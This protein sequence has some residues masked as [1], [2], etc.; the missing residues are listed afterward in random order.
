M[1]A[2]PLRT[3]F[4]MS[5]PLIRVCDG[6]TSSFT[7]PLVA[8]ST[9]LTQGASACDGPHPAGEFWSA[10]VSLI[11]CAGAGLVQAKE[12]A[13]SPIRASIL[14]SVI[15]S[16][17]LAARL[18]WVDV[19]V[20]GGPRYCRSPCRS[21]NRHCGELHERGVSRPA[22][23]PSSGYGAGAIHGRLEPAGASLR[24]FSALRSRARG[25]RDGRQR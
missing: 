3:P 10:K 7:R 8:S 4:H 23:G 21:S 12:T 17:S 5:M 16:L 1:S 9:C 15:C 14:L 22:R 25:D 6:K 11:C 20:G 24:I 2:M 18:S 19:L 13:T